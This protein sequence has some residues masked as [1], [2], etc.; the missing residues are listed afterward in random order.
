[1]KDLLSYGR[2]DLTVEAI[3]LKDPYNQ[4]FCPEILEKARTRLQQMGYEV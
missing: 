1:M 2:L 3:I 4:L